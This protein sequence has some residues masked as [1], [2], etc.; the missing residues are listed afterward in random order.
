MA[1][2]VPIQDS[3]I[4]KPL[5]G[6]TTTASGIVIPDTVSQDKPMKGTVIAVGPGKKVNGEMITSPVNEGDIVIFRQYAQT[7]VKV[8]G[9][10]LYVLN[11]DG[12]L[13]TEVQ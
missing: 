2:L 5:E 3:L 8:D 9:E 7:E 12:V 13:A 10:E 4:V 1:K 11:F 6:Q